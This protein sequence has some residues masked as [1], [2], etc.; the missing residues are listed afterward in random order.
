MSAADSRRRT[1]NLAWEP[2]AR[3]QSQPESTIAPPPSNTVK[4]LFRPQPRR[5][6]LR[7]YAW[8]LYLGGIAY[9]ICERQR[10]KH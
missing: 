3:L 9:D 7:H 2:L 8:W 10:Q 6:V 5:S 1:L 4:R